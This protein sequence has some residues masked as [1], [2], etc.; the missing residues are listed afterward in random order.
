MSSLIKIIIPSTIAKD[1]NK[2]TTLQGQIGR[3]ICGTEAQMRYIEYYTDNK[4]RNQKIFFA[5]M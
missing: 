5:F 3:F 4:L 1:D 2:Y